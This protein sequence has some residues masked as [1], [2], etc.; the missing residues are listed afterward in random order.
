[1]ATQSISIGKQVVDVTNALSLTRGDRYNLQNIGPYD[2]RLSEQAS[3]PDADD[4][5]I[6]ILRPRLTAS[7]LVASA[8]NLYAWVAPTAAGN[9]RLTVGPS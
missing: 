5:R 4:N 7:Y 1:M 9:G 2:I 8:E 3:A 6:N